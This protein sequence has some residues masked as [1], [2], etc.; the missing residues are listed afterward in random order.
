MGAFGGFAGDGWEGYAGYNGWDAFP[1]ALL[2]LSTIGA[3]SG[4]GYWPVYPGYADLGYYGDYWGSNPSAVLGYYDDWCNPLS[5]VI[6][7][8][9]CLMM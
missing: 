9:M 6:E 2:G 4:V 8:W 1:A 5:L 3:L 7:P